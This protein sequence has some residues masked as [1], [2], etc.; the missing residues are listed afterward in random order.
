MLLLNKFISNSIFCFYS[1]IFAIL[2]F[3]GNAYSQNIRDSSSVAPVAPTNSLSDSL[4][5]QS[6]TPPPI[7]SGG[8]Q[9]P[10]DS[11]KTQVPRDSSISPNPTTT[12]PSVPPISTQNPILDTTK[13][14]NK[15]PV[16]E[17]KR[18]EGNK[19]NIQ[20]V[21]QMEFVRNNVHQ[22]PDSSYFN[23]LKI[24]NNNGNVIK[25][26]VTIS[27]PHGWK[28]ISTEKTTVNIIPGQ[29]EYIP[30]RA[31]MSRSVVGGV[32]YLIN[33]TIH[34][35]RSLVHG[36][37]QTSASKT[38]YVSI[39]QKRKWEIQPVLRTVYFDRYSEY[40][41]MKLQLSN[42]GNGTE[43][44]KL[45]FQIGGSLQM[46]GSLGKKYF[47]AI[48]LKPHMD[49]V[50]S[51]LVKYIQPEDVELFNRDFKKLSI[52]V[53]A[54][55]DTIV[56]K[57][58]FNFKHLESSYCNKL[59]DILGPLNV[60]VQLQNLI[61][62][63]DPTWLLKFYGMVLLKNKAV[64]DYNFQFM[65]LPFYG[66]NKVSD[67]SSYYWRRS[68][69]WVGYKTA[70]WEVKVGD[71]YSYGGSFFGG[72]GRGIG[73]F[74][75]VNDNNKVGAAL[76]A[77][78]TYRIY[79]ATV[80]HETTLFKKVY[81]KT[82]LNT[83]LDNYNKLNM[84]GGSVQGNY[85]FLPGHNLT[86]LLASSL[87]QHNYNNQ[88]FLDSQGG[89]IT[90]S[91]PGV[92]QIGYGTQLGYQLSKN[93]LTADVNLFYSSK[94]FAQYNSGKFNLNGNVRYMFNKKYSLV[95]ISNVFLQ[96]PHIYVRGT[97]NP[98]NKYLSGSHKLEFVNKV[99]NKF[100]FYAGPVLE[101][102][103]YNTVKIQKNGFATST[104][105]STISPKISV[106]GSYKNNTSG[107]VSPYAMVGLT[108]ITSALDSTL[109][110]STHVPMNKFLSARAGVN[111]LQGNWGANMFYYIG[112]NDFVSQS[113]FYYFGRYSKSIRIIP[114][115]QKYYFGRR[116]LLTSYDS[117]SYEVLSNSERIT[118]N[119]RLKYVVGK[120][121][122]MYVD[123]N[124][125]LSSRITTD[126]LKVY[127]RNFYLSLGVKKSFDIPQPLVKYY[128]L[129]VVCFK[130]INGN[131][132]MDDNEQGLADVVITIDRK[133]Q[134]KSG[135][136]QLGQFSP[137][138]MVTDNVG[139]LTYCK[140]P[141][142]EFDL[143]I[144]PLFNLKDLYNVN[145]QRQTG[146]ISRDTTYY[147]PFVQSYRVIGK[148]IL[149]RDEF[150]GFGS[151]SPSNI[152]VLA[153][154]S[155]GNSFSSLTNKDGSYTLFVPKAG[156][157]KVSV[158]NIFDNQFT[159][160]ESEYYVIFNGARVFEIDFIF[161]EKKR[162]MNLNGSPTNTNDSEK[163]IV[164]KPITPTS[165]VKDSVSKNPPNSKGADKKNQINPTISPSPSGLGVKQ[166][167]SSGS[168]INKLSQDS[169]SSSKV[170]SNSGFKN[171]SLAR[172]DF[173][174]LPQDSISAKKLTDTTQIRKAEI[175]GSFIP[176]PPVK[177]I[178]NGISYRIQFASSKTRISP[179]DYAVKFK[180]VDKVK[181]YVLNGAYKYTAGD[182]GT[183]EY[184]V[185][186]EYKDKLKAMGYKDAF[187]VYFK[188]NKR[189]K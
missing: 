81:F 171:E 48:E 106:R 56:K 68:R 2:V 71:V 129:K 181:E 72:A 124:L 79:S 3:G 180:G 95:A 82:A 121:W 138:E 85:S 40:S 74:Y 17:E 168:R 141:E 142:G 98:E 36:R 67:P 156:E 104:N 169:I 29:T 19:S 108:Y 148:I 122:D 100:S 147:V 62:K 179:K 84:F 99:N 113:D 117:Y 59:G 189:R 162:K 49:T 185:A 130:D 127:N 143:N 87:T 6:S 165:S 161:D 54:K 55:V 83:F 20:S 66:Y 30:I 112:P 4:K 50:V 160:Q 135:V 128:N 13:S 133:A 91:D 24:T 132:V 45:E 16:F 175:T 184:D 65:N 146:A 78:F 22:G 1:C 137:V 96:N 32:S 152:R 97:L 111:F 86:F 14:Q 10:V 26:I 115:F 187:M 102:L 136:D 42:R 105:F 80:F 101:H 103:S 88:T 172:S 70:R 51:F 12:T 77:S 5:P 123:N 43:V 107:F 34:S 33:A 120:G 176:P 52:S 177:D 154:D 182:F 18:S 7:I 90:T 9:S 39:P 110:N 21:V 134:L 178:S 155:A 166:D 150:S 158:N 8:P 159:Q 27:L 126:N 89:F 109:I 153:T 38:C 116:L 163:P 63:S 188:N 53:V 114:Y 151:I 131:F 118:L 164:K 139:Q 92:S 47:T 119:A 61:S 73:G 57:T 60:E 157:Y 23:I 183:F 46:Y 11:L 170:D 174:K 75:K 93:K 145:G 35:D 149:N 186:T 94:Y 44:I 37:N 140:I 64:F 173:N 167:S 69:M 41:P 58:S 76:S 125:Y 144:V 31:S 25:G 15:T 28:L